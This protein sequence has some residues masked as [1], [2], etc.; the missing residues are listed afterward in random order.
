MHVFFG[1]I[2]FC[3]NFNWSITTNQEQKMNKSRKIVWYKNVQLRNV[4]IKNNLNI[5]GFFLIYNKHDGADP[6]IIRHSPKN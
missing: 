2:F 1:N 6:Y 3:Q 5:S 4:S